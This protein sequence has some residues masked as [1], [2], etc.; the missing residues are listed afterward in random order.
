MHV[1]QVVVCSQEKRQKICDK[2]DDNDVEE[3]ASEQVHAF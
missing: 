2:I 3:S 1:W